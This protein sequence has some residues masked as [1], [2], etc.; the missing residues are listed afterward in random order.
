MQ[1]SSLREQ[2]I[3]LEERKPKQLSQERLFDKITASPKAPLQGIV[4]VVYS[5]KP[6]N[7]HSDRT[8]LMKAQDDNTILLSYAKRLSLAFEQQPDCIE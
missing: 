4:N 3:S 2:V 6:S 8:N 7:Q 5:I 1:A